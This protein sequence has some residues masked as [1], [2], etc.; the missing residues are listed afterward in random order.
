MTDD[1]LEQPA[2]HAEKASVSKK[3]AGR[4]TS[5][6]WELFT[7]DLDSQRQISSTCRH[8]HKSLVYHKKSE[9]VKDHL[10]NC[11]EFAIAMMDMDEDSRPVWFQETLSNK[12][13]KSGQSSLSGISLSQTSMKDFCLPRLKQS[14]LKKIENSLAM[15]FYIT[16]TSFQRVEEKYLIDAFKV[17][18]PDVVLPNRKILAGRALERTYEKVRIESEKALKLSNRLGCVITDASSNTNN[19]SIINYMIV[20]DRLS[21]FL[22]SIATEEQSHTAE[23]IADDL[24]R[25]IQS[26]T[27]REIKIAGAVTDNTATNRKAWTELQRRY[28]KMYFHGCAS[29]GLHLLVKDIFAATKAKKG[30]PTADYPEGYPFEYLLNFVQDCKDV[31]SFFSYH[32]QEKAKLVKLQLAESKRQLVQPAATRWGS[33][34]NSKRRLRESESILH[35]IVSAR[36]FV[37]GTQKQ[38]QRRQQLMDT[39]CNDNFVAYLDKCIEILEPID[40]GIKTFQDDHVSISTVY[41]HFALFMKQSYE[42]MNCLSSEERSYILNLVRERLEFMYGD[43]IGI[44][45]LLDPVI[46]GKN[47]L[48]EHKVRAEDAL[49]ES[50]CRGVV[51]NDENRKEYEAK[52]EQLFVEY[53]DWVIKATSDQTKNDFRFKMLSKGTKT[54]IQYWLID[55]LAHPNLREVAINVFSMVA[56]SAASERGFSAMGFVHSKLRNRLSADKVQKLIFIKNNASQL[57]STDQV[58]L[59]WGSNDSDEEEDLNEDEG[60]IGDTK[61]TIEFD[62]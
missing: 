37:I 36:D 14:E 44:A 38:K 34:I 50:A 8:C 51:I 7:D 6:L 28:P 45:Y 11:K 21:Q 35:R 9:R 54:C 16:G 29:H 10:Q 48:N 57:M 4:Q 24:D 1:L 41:K 2:I 32:Q 18:R 15:H 5:T 12:K 46:L 60:Q 19:E 55:G 17:A 59:D 39:I 61:S 62:E 33:L 22:E 52:K 23:F 53:T 25:V 26:L 49:F 27:A 13:Q 58:S 40:I 47:M 3:R 43:A 31:V 20:S 56:S 42:N 30:R